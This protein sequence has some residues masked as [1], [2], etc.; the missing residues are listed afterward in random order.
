[1]DSCSYIKSAKSWL[2]YRILN[3][4]SIEDTSENYVRPRT[5]ADC[6]N[7]RRPCPWVGCRHH[8]YLD[9]TEAGGIRLNFPDK[10]PWELD[11]CCALDIIDQYGDRTLDQVGRAV[12][13]TCERVRQIE[14]DACAKVKPY[15]KRFK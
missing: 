15:L 1:V 10:R 13:L 7:S 9:I 2:H 5:R 14:L 12:N 6:K 8:L 4:I 11:P 3:E